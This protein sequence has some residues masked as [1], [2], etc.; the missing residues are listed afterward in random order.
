MN[1][2]SR[3][4][5]CSSAVCATMLSCAQTSVPMELDQAESL[6]TTSTGVEATFQPS[7]AP[8][9]LAA[10][11][12]WVAGGLSL[13]QALQL[14]LR[15]QQGLQVELLEIGLAQADLVQAG[16]L[17]NPTLDLAIRFPG[18]GTGTLID[19]L[20]GF[21]LM[22]LWQV[23]AREQAAGFELEATIARIA[24]QAG[25]RLATTREAYL[26]AVAADEARAISEGESRLAE[27]MAAQVRTL[28]G[29]GMVDRPTSA[30]AEMDAL[31]S[32]ARLRKA[33][34]EAGEAKRNLAKAMSVQIPFEEVYLTD[35]LPAH[36]DVG[37]DAEIWVDAALESR[38]D[39][40]ALTNKV[41]ALEAEVRAQE[42]AGLGSLSLGPNMEDP[43][44]GDKSFGP[45]LAW[46]IPLFDRNQVGI[47]KA[48]FALE[49]ARHQLAGARAHIAQDVRSAWASHRWSWKALHQQ[50]QE[51]L[52][53]ARR[54]VRQMEDA[55]GV[56]IASETKLLQARREAL[57]VESD[58][59]RL[60]LDLAL[61][62]LRLER[63]VGR[64]L[65]TSAL[66]D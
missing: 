63:A 23:P 30:A 28:E 12:E 46:T 36:V 59:V 25:D 58:G 8:L 13:E 61:A 49:Q 19:A 9:D 21:E 51:A 34:G 57:S 43:G 22:D 52:S 7:A 17:T 56:G 53:M 16:L 29:L 45:G 50:E 35:A 4:A 18:D 10:Q 55:V 60:R 1:K 54:T 40:Q 42:R 14:T 66:V 6:V 2:L 24:R 44:D 15:Q 5:F 11:R 37:E 26:R 3:N 31:R 47:A 65:V 39:L 48:E 20:L 33:A 32:S 27:T 41:A 38:L 64:P 62:E